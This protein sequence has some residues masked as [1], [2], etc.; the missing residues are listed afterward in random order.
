[1]SE[2]SSVHRLEGSSK[3][4]GG[5][6]IKKKPSSN[7]GTKSL[8]FK[9]PQPRSS[10]L[11]LDRLA[12]VKRREKE[13]LEDE[14]KKRS[15]VTSYKDDWED[16]DEDE[17][18]EEEEE[19]EVERGSSQIASQKRSVSLI[20]SD[21]FRSNLNSRKAYYLLT[22]RKDQLMFLCDCLRANFSN[23]PAR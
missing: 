8:S 2:D 20:L 5:L 11:G 21:Y 1:M 6:I 16:G 4:V 9:A 23:S 3:Q 18:E 13:E 15:K 14:T 22:C 10:L 19:D 17:E 12:A 7:D